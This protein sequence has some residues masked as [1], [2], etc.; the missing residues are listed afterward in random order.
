VSDPIVPRLRV[1]TA[2]ILTVPNFCSNQ[3][4]ENAGYIGIRPPDASPRSPALR[5]LEVAYDYALGSLKPAVLQTIWM[6]DNLYRDL[7][8]PVVRVSIVTGVV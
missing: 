1:E 2:G 6:L 4:R 3:R 7:T 8:V 5:K